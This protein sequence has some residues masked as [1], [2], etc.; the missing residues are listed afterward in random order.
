MAIDNILYKESDGLMLDINVS[1]SGPASNILFDDVPG[2]VENI[3]QVHTGSVNNILFG[4]NLMEI[5]PTELIEIGF[6]R[7]G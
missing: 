2:F 6:G 1:H 3:S 7:F 4:E 5:V